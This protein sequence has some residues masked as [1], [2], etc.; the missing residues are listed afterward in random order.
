[1][2][3]YPPATPARQPLPG[4]EEPAADTETAKADPE[5]AKPTERLAEEVFGQTLE[6]IAGELFRGRYENA[7]LV[8]GERTR[9]AALAVAPERLADVRADLAAAQGMADRV[10]ASF[11]QDRGKTVSVQLR[12]GKVSLLVESVANGRV[13]GSTQVEQGKFGQSF[14][15]AELAPKE[16]LSRLGPPED[17]DRQGVLPGQPRRLGGGLPAL[18]E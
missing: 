17:K 16:I 4:P 6:Q 18:A 11:A 5:P 8:W 15:P 13:Y 7:S 9:D 10:L 14:T 3:A 12:T 1:L 2:A